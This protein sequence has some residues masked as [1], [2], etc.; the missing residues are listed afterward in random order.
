LRRDGEEPVIYQDD[1][2]IDGQAWDAALLY[3][4]GTLLYYLEIGS[5]S[6]AAASTEVYLATA[7]LP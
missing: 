6:G 3:R 1:L 7:N 2:P 4:D 5:A